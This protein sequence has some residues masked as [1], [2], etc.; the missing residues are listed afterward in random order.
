[1][2]RRTK[3][4]L[5][6]GA[7]AAGSAAAAYGLVIRPWR[8]KWRA[9]PIDVK[10]PM[11]GDELVDEPDE[12]TNRAMTIEANPTDIW[13]WLVDV[14]KEFREG[15]ILAVGATV[16]LRIVEMDDERSLVLVPTGLPHGRASWSILLFP[17]APNRTR[18]ICR[19]RLHLGSS[20]PDM[21]FRMVV[22]PAAMMQLR[23]WFDA[24]KLRAEHTAAVRA[25]H[26]RLEQLHQ[27]QHAFQSKRSR[28]RG[29]L[30][31]S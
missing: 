13:Q 29:T 30:R 11:P 31:P 27:P 1:M 14:G 12:V 4:A 16:N 7:L 5:A 26:E 17:Y 2:N 22:V 20:I 28:P 8:R 23:E 19:T 3:R 15:D 10:R 21:L 25:Q 24:V 6:W 18:L 9:E